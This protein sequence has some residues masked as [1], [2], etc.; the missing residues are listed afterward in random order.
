MS[1]FI[2]TI[3]VLGDDVVMDSIIERTITEF[4]DDQITKINGSGAFKGC[5]QLKTVWLPN[6]DFD[7]TT[8]I[9]YQFDSCTSL[10]D[11]QIPSAKT[12]GRLMFNNCTSLEHLVLPSVIKLN[13]QTFVKCSN[14]T[15]L[16]FHKTINTFGIGHINGCSKLKGIIFRADEV[17]PCGNNPN[18]VGT[19]YQ[20]GTGY[21]YVPGY[22][23]SSYKSAEN[24]STIADQFRGIIDDEEALQGIIDETLVDHEN[25][26]I[27][28]IPAFSFYNYAPL[29]SVKS[30][31]VETVETNAF[32]G[33]TALE[34]VE[35][36]GATTIQHRAFL[37]CT[38]LESIKIPNVNTIRDYAFNNCSKLKEVVFETDVWNVTVSAFENCAAL[39]KVEF[40]KASILKYANY[41]NTALS[42]LILRNTKVDTLDNINAL[43][44]T[45]IANGA[46]YIYV[47]RSLIED[48]KVAENWSTFAAQF[49]ALEDYTVDGTTT[50]ELDESKI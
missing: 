36:L 35:L 8:Q 50:G 4:K 29:K 27:E 30:T 46:G 12:L 11:I 6:A 31:S 41:K 40:K 10:V 34:N 39:K 23:V 19:P 9:G 20:D 16:D 2:N 18:W 5:S 25:N 3:D 47:P 49:R 33:C 45:P 48:Y 21:I 37:N 14:L 42:A 15:T 7:G 26:E 38:S 24:W 1:D 44:G 32:D 43:E 17:V 22:L 28:S 13:I